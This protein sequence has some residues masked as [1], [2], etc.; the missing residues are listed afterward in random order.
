MPLSLRTLIG[1]LLLALDHITTAMVPPTLSPCFGIAAAP[2][3]DFH[4]TTDEDVSDQMATF[5]EAEFPPA[6]RTRREVEAQESADVEVA[7][8][9][10][11]LDSQPE[12]L[13]DTITPAPA[14]CH[15][16]V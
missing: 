6:E 12:Q 15:R 16:L 8:R 4:A 3:T 13:L 5:K 7:R 1:I 10:I 9:A 2:S 11:N 14:R